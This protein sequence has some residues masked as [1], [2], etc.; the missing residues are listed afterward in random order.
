[1][2]SWLSVM[3][4]WE[5]LFCF[6]GSLYV[7]ILMLLVLNTPQYYSQ[8]TNRIEVPYNNH[9][10]E[11]YDSV[12]PNSSN[13]KRKMTCKGE[14]ISHENQMAS[15]DSSKTAKLGVTQI[16]K[17][18]VQTPDFLWLVCFVLTYKLGEQGVISMLPLFLLDQGI[19]HVQVGVMSGIFGQVCSIAG[20]T[21]GGW[22][23]GLHHGQR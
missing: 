18:I 6:W 15:S 16:L 1:M 13:E 22:I 4:S 7:I 11:K 20:S 14:M 9:T 8:H 12:S 10:A 21:V 3:C 17:N 23:V 2:L 19:P 5:W